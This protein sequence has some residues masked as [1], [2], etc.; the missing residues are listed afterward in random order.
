MTTEALNKDARYL[1]ARLLERVPGIEV[2]VTP[3]SGRGRVWWLDACFNG[4][5]IVVEWS[6]EDG[7]GLSATEENDFDTAPGQ[8][9]EDADSALDRIVDILRSGKKVSSRREMEIEL[10]AKRLEE[11]DEDPDAA[12]PWEDV[13]EQLLR[14][15]ATSPRTCLRGTR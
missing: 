1:A 15:E 9:F 5:D 2:K 11:D 7:F 6:Q 8:I 14:G 4:H 10:L 12:V 3:P 13:R